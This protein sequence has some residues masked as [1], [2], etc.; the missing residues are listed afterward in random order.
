MSTIAVMGT[1]GA[2]LVFFVWI[3][4]VIH[5]SRAVRDAERRFRVAQEG[6]SQDEAVIAEQRLCD[7]KLR[8]RRL[9]FR[10]SQPV[11]LR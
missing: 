6:S 4:R 5:A 2:G 11:S 3:W 10:S 7:R 9:T 8:L 1:I